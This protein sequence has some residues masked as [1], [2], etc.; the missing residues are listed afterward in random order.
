MLLLIEGGEVYAP[1]A[2]GRADVLVAGGK[3]IRVGGVDRRAVETLDPDYYVIDAAGRVVTPGFI[4]PHEHL[5]GGSGEGGF[6]AQS[7]EIRLHELLLGGITTVVGV[8]GVD[9]TMKNMPALVG[10]AKALR[11]CGLTAFCWTG[12]YDVPATTLT[13][14]VRN[15]LLFVEEVIG[16]GEIAISDERS[17]DPSLHELARLASDAFIGGHLARKAGLTHFHVGPGARRLALLRRLVDDFDVKPEWLYPTH[18]ER[19]EGLMDEAIALARRGAAVDV[20]V[21]EKDLPKWFRYYR[22]HGGPA[23]RLTASTDASFSSP[24]D[25]LDQVRACLGELGVPPAEVLPVVTS[26]TADILKLPGKG[27]ITP[28]ADADLLVLEAGSLDLVHVV[29]GG[30]VLVEAGRPA[31]DEPGVAAARRPGAGGR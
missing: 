19:S 13:G 25:L 7:P 3:I 5:L 21:V 26:N 14:S 1:E 31:A 20:D 12:G 29:A 17:L 23:G 11:E 16:A 22:E 8:L 18:V 27:R 4:D 2:R 28:G 6:A 9:T 30:R 10:R 15:D 24:R